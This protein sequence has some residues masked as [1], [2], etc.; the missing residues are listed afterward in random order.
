MRSFKGRALASLLAV[1]ASSAPLPAT[2]TPSYVPTGTDIFED[3]TA[4]SEPRADVPVGALWVQNFGPFGE[5]AAADNLVTVR[6]VSGLSLNRE[7]NF[8]LTL[9][10]LSFL[11]IDPALRSQVSARFT[12]LTIV[13]VKEVAKLPGPSG[14]PRIYEAIKAGAVTVTLNN[15][16]GTDLGT[17]FGA[18]SLP[19]VGRGQAGRKR[20]FTIEGRDLFIAYRVVTPKLV[21]QEPRE[22]ELRDDGVSL[23]SG[24]YRLA[25]SLGELEKCLCTARSTAETARCIAEAEIPVVLSRPNGS[26]SGESVVRSKLRNGVATNIKLPM[27]ISDG[28]GGVLTSLSAALSLRSSKR[29]GGQEGCFATVGGKSKIVVTFEGE[30]LESSKSPHARGW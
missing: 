18:G 4:L 3:Y 27:P 16:V 28:A 13:R 26:A 11:N 21:K 5:G 12:D 29:D 9:G 19:A 8:R 14:E 2:A 23:G 30:R 17:G 15:D 7:Q 24:E 1:A 20:S 22:V 6:S 25:A 10:L